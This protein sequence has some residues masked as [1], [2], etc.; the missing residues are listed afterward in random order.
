M[1]L[2]NEGASTSLLGHLKNQ[3][4]SSG[5]EPRVIRTGAFKGLRMHLDLRRQAQVYLGLYERELHDSLSEFGRDAVT[6]LDV[7]VSDGAYSLYFLE[8]T[9]ARTIYAFEPDPAG[10]ELFLSNLQLNGLDRDPRLRL[11]DAPAGSGTTPDTLA[12]DSLLSSIEV[13]C[14]A[15]VDVEGYEAEVLAGA[16]QLLARGGISWI[17]ETHSLALEQTCVRVLESHGLA[18]KIV[19]PAWWR[20]AVPEARPIPHNRWLVAA[21]KGLAGR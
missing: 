12:L 19:S 13:P 7:G 17:I 6:A 10:R 9:Q 18:V 8:R 2:L 15:K 1:S 16:A 20:W 5:S 21:A 11:V 3:V 4:V 14:V